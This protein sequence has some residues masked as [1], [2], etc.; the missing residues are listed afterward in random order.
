VKNMQVLV[1][2]ARVHVKNVQVLVL[3]V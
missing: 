2:N 1:S 3:N